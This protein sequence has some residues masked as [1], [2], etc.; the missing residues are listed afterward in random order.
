MGSVKGVNFL[1]FDYMKRDEFRNEIRRRYSISDDDFVF[2]FAARI[3]KDKGINE[4]LEAFKG[5]LS[6]YNNVKLLICGEEDYNSCINKQLIDWAKNNNNIIFCGYVKDIEKHY[7]A[8]DV[9]LFPTYR[10]GFGEVSLEAQAMGTPVITTDVPGPAESVK[11]EVGGLHIKSRDS[12]AL[13]KAMIHIYN[14]RLIL[15]EMNKKAP[16]WVKENFNSEKLI[17]EIC[18]FKINMIEDS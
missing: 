6:T 13:L 10:E 1:R 16:D 12:E 3:T 8:M 2:G 11:E 5:F 7:A 9:F 18:K 4:T 15:S 17:K 14:D